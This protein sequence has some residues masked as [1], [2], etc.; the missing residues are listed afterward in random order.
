MSNKTFK[1]VKKY[2]FRPSEKQI[3]L[4]SSCRFTAECLSSRL[5]FG[6]LLSEKDTALGSAPWD[7]CVENVTLTSRDVCLRLK[8]I[9]IPIAA[10]TVIAALKQFNTLAFLYQCSNATLWTSWMFKVKRLPLQSIGKRTHTRSIQS[11]CW[12][13]NKVGRCQIPIKALQLGIGA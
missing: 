8:S 10:V 4:D 1:Y 13:Q 9:A 5:S 11:Y 12:P 2:I 3:L 7:F 6:F